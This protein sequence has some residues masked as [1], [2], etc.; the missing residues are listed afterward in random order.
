MQKTWGEIKNETLNLGFEKSNVYAKNKESFI[1]AYNWAQNY[2]AVVTGSVIGTLDLEKKACK[3]PV[4]RDLSELAEE[5]GKTFLSV[6]DNGIIDKAT[7]K[8]LNDIQLRNNRYLIMPA[9]HDGDITVWYV[10]SP[11]PIT[12]SSADNTVCELPYKW[13]TLMPYYMA[14]RLFMDDD[15]GK[16]GYYWNLAEDMRREIAAQENSLSVTVVGGID[17]DGWCI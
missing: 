12:S 2:I 16:A 17:I 6:A 11:E 8:K 4:M 9:E 7:G 1:G 5:D 14:N 15:A 10:H 3:L 13:A